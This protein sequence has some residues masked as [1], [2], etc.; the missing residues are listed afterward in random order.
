ML[1]LKCPSL[2]CGQGFAY[3]AVLTKHLIEYVPAQDSS[4]MIC[5]FFFKG[6]QEQN[7]AATEHA[8][9]FIGTSVKMMTVGVAISLV[10]GSTLGLNEAVQALVDESEIKINEEV[11]WV[12]SYIEITKPIL[13]VAAWN[14]KWS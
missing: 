5:Y 2:I 14:T 13:Q 9:W 11:I 3:R 8:K 4:G 12:A 1:K 7:S 6:N 10:L